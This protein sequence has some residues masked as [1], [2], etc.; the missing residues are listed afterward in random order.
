[1]TGTDAGA[2]PSGEPAVEVDGLAKRYGAGD[3]LVQ[4]LHDVGFTIHRGEFVVLLGP[5]GSGKTTMLNLIGAI[6]APSAGRLRVDGIDVTGLDGRAATDFRRHRVGF[7]FQ[8]YNLVPTLTA[9][10]NV[11]LIAEVT[12]REPAMRAREALRAVQL[13]ARMHHYPGQLSGGEQQRVAIARALV[14]APPLVLADEPTGALDLETGREVLGLLHDVT[15]YVAST[16]FV[17][18]HNSAIAA[19]ADRVLRLRDG[20]VVGDERNLEPSDAAEITW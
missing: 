18:T 8:F 4:A 16:V 17:V 7:V 19:M 6:E 10:E 12:G 14:K 2:T 1:M 20:T 3:T 11:E 13:D 5:S 9:F 15:R